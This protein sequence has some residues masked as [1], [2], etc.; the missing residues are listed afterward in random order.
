MRKFL[1]KLGGAIPRSLLHAVTLLLLIS[2]TFCHAQCPTP[3]VTSIT[4][5][6][7]FA[8]QTYNS[9]TFTGTD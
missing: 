8:G 1:G 4:P 9:V 6:V 3:T 5:D 7:W 2:S